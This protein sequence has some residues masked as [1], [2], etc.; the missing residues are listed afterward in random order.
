MAGAVDV[1]DQRCMIRRHN[2]RGA[3]RDFSDCPGFRL[4]S[5]YFDLYAL[6]DMRSQDP[7]HFRHIAMHCFST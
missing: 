5:V 7:A 2:V 6:E 4:T 1:D 3:A